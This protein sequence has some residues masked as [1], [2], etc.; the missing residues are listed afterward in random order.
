M[1]EIIHS[2]LSVSYQILR[3]YFYLM[4]ATLILSWTPIRNTRFYNVLEKITMV[5]L[6]L[7]R[8]WLVV[9]QIDLTPILGLILYQFIL[10]MI[11]R[12]L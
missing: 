8:G 5:Y 2:I 10:Q 7:F 12:A 9:G 6:N 4:F 11:G 3:V 1:P